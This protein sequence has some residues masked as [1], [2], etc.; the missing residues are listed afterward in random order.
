MCVGPLS[1]E[2]S[3]GQ[4]PGTLYPLSNNPVLKGHNIKTQM[5]VLVLTCFAPPQKRASA[6]SVLLDPSYRVFCVGKPCFGPV[7]HFHNNSGVA[8]AHNQ[9][10]SP[11]LQ[12][13]LLTMW[14][15]PCD[16]RYSSAANS[17][18]IPLIAFRLSGTLSGVFVGSGRGCF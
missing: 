14:L 5:G 10:H 6:N 18:R 13:K 7:S 12:R 2:I 17:P 16:L 1:V 15:K 8:L 3:F 9:I 11:H 4:V